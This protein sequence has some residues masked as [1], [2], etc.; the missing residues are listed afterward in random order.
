LSRVNLMCTVMLM[1]KPNNG[2]YITN[3]CGL[4]KNK[5]TI[6]CNAGK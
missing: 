2:W 6:A 3:V 5:K 4:E 1:Q